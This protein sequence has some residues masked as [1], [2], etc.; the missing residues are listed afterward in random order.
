MIT[1]RQLGQS[2]AL[3]VGAIAVPGALQAQSWP[4]RPIRLV[5]P[6]PPGGLI[7]TMARLIGPR[8]SLSLGQPVVVD[9]KPGAG[10]NLGA[11]EVARALPDGYTL[12]MAAPP[13][14]IGPALYSTLPY[15]PEQIAAVALLGS[16]PNVLLVKSSSPITS[17]KQ[18]TAQAKASPGK[19]NYA[20]NGVGTSLHLCAELYK[21]TTGVFVT[22]IPYR[23]AAAAMTALLSGEVTMMFDNL[24]GALAQIQ[25]GNVRALA[26]TTTTRS[27][28]LPDVATMVESGLTGFDVSAWF[29]VAAPTATAANV[30]SRLEQALDAVI[31]QA[32]VVANMSRQ[33]V[34]PGFSG[35]AS[36]TQFL[37]ADSA[38]WKAVAA[39][40]KISLD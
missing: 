32:D 38:K 20:S 8:L 23:G 33:G 9:N 3:A 12:L 11:A 25:A 35:S 6:F 22:H 10:G 1:R 5:V 17:L 21:S 26:V 30:V 13:L 37:A 7:D 15:K 27:K 39:Y 2:A 40:A 16:V 34:E 24:P 31:K 18:L 4:S 29:G 36:M 19:L 14:T 28:S